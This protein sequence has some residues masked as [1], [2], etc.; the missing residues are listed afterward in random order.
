MLKQL[1]YAEVRRV[2]VHGPR[3]EPEEGKLGLLSEMCLFL[4]GKAK[5]EPGKN[6]GRREILKGVMSGGSGERAVNKVF[7]CV[8]EKNMTLS[9]NF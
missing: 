1:L 2:P 7:I 5:S 3:R 4:A 6:E 9:Q 8:Q